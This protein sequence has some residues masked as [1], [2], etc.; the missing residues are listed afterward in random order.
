MKCHDVPRLEQTGCAQIQHVCWIRR[1][2]SKMLCRLHKHSEGDIEVTV[3][4][5]DFVISVPQRVR[6]GSLL[7]EAQRHPCI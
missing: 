4:L 3:S 6:C 2:S 1:L 5:C 7:F